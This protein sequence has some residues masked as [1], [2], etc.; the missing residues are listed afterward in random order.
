MSTQHVAADLCDSRMAA[1]IP[2]NGS[3]DADLLDEVSTITNRAR[4][5]VRNN[6]IASGVRQTLIDNIIGSQL[7]LSSQP[8]YRLLGKDKDW[9]S[10]WGGKVEDEFATWAD[11]VECDIARSNTFLGLTTQG[12]SGA[13]TNGDGIG[14]IL[15]QPRKGARWSTRLQVVEADRM[16]TPPWL[17]NKANLRKGVEI[18][19]FGA[20]VA[21]WIMKYHPGDKHAYLNLAN[22]D[23][24][25]RIPAFTPWGRRR[26]IHLYDKERAGQSRGKSIFT[27]VMREFKTVGEY[28]GSEVQAAA[29]NALIASIV[30][31]DLPPDMV[32]DLLGGQEGGVAGHY[33]A[34]VDSY[35]RKKMEGGMNLVAPLGTKITGFST[36]RPNVAFNG[37]MEA[38]MRH[39][40][41]GLNLP[42]ELLVKDFSKTNYSSARAALLEAWRFFQ[43]KRSWLRDQWLDPCFE[44]WLEEAVNLGRID[45]PDYYDNQ[46]AYSACR[47]IFAGRG[48]VDPTKEAKAS[49]LRMDAGLSTLENEAAEQGLDWY[50]VLEQRARERKAMEELGLL[51]PYQLAAATPFVDTTDPNAPQGGSN[52]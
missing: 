9:A 52:A 40:A 23:N 49:Q 2:R 28:M 31:S 25:V 41:A 6:P 43:V 21:Y 11:T 15:W 47:W 30:E 22:Q 19:D 46:Y 14:V 51:E 13:F 37:F 39:I 16:D 12:A 24:W 42:Y 3:A 7:R 38:V 32:A 8:S 29:S 35:H 4:D 36:N 45:A 1:W 34:I 50:E 27:A 26:V 18:D 20:P 44:A 5:L 48:W 10:E 33:Q 17:I